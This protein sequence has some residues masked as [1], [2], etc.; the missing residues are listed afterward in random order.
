MAA[1]PSL[2]HLQKNPSTEGVR[3]VETVAVPRRRVPDRDLEVGRRISKG[4]RSYEASSIQM[5]C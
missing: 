2:I 5:W 1:M 3:T 4:S